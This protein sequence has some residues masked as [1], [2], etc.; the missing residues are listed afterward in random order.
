[1]TNK[2]PT[3]ATIG[4]KHELSKLVF[5]VLQLFFLNSNTIIKPNSLFSNTKKENE[6]DPPRSVIYSTESNDL[7]FT[8]VDSYTSLPNNEL[9][10]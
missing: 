5:K 2:V 1:M 9:Y 8:V 10:D 6:L 7:Y 4:G 3:S